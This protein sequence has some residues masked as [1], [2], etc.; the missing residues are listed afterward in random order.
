MKTKMIKAK[1]NALL[2]LQFYRDRNGTL[3]FLITSNLSEKENL[4]GAGASM[5]FYIFSGNFAECNLLDLEQKQLICKMFERA[6][7]KIKEIEHNKKLRNVHIYQ[8]GMVG[9]FDGNKNQ[10]P[11]LQGAW[12]DKKAEIFSAD[13]GI[14]SYQFGTF[15]GH[16]TVID[17]DTARRLSIE[18]A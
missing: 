15:N 7:V 4:K 16:M 12:K 17:R 5:D 9:C 1:E 3:G 14:V 13:D 6:N 10:I 11:Y 2:S 18:V 8:N